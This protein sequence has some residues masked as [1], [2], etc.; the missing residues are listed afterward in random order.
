M[1]AMRGTMTSSAV[2]EVLT[3]LF[4]RHGL[5]H[6]LISDNGTM[7]TSFGFRA[8]VASSG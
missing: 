5:L 3:E 2:I 8:F 1:R 7:L 6:I 4:A